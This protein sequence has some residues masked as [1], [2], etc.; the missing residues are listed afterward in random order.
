MSNAKDLNLIIQNA[1]SIIEHPS[2]RKTA[3]IDITLNSSHISILEKFE[4][5]ELSFILKY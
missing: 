3:L 5:E 2:I 4:R 1:N